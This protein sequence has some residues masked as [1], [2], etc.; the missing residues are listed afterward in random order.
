MTEA[1]TATNVI[2]AA[3]ECLS[4]AGYAVV[5]AKESD[6]WTRRPARLFEDPY[7]IVG[8]VVFDTWGELRE[9]WVSAQAGLVERI[10][11]HMSRADAK[12][13]DA[14]L[15]L[16]TPAVVPRD[17]VARA[18]HIRYDTSRL[19]KLLATGAELTTLSAVRDALLPL[20]PVAEEAS[21]HAQESSLDALPRVLGKRGFEES[22]IRELIHAF[23]EQEPLMTTLHKVRTK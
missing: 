22:I 5:G 20:L 16:F 14:Y 7:S 11:D 23:R 4:S 17:Q 21:V 3:T 13:W 2:A 6:P 18:Q 19:R 8:V 10:G 12:S 1:L 15:A 9:E